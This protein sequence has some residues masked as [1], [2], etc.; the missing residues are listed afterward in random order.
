M[1]INCWEMKKNTVKSDF[2]T[3]KLVDGKNQ[4]KNVGIS[5]NPVGEGKCLLCVVNSREAIRL[6]WSN[7]LD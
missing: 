7:S 5:E 3:S 6:D 4:I 2:K 1:E